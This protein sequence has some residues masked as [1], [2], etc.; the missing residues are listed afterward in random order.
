MVLSLIFRSVTFAERIVESLSSIELLVPFRSTL[1]E[2]ITSAFLSP[3]K[4]FKVLF[5]FNGMNVQFNSWN[6]LET[7]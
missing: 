4:M 3:E 2:N 1:K 5:L 7:Q 6:E